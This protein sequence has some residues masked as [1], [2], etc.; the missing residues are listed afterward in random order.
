MFTVFVF[1]FFLC[2]YVAHPVLSHVEFDLFFVVN[3]PL[4]FIFDN[5]AYSGQEAI[6][7]KVVPQI[8]ETM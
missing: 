4:S 2:Q 3:S 5:T 8:G 7:S 1:G 6:F